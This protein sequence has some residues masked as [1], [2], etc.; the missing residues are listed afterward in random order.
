M[1][2]IGSLLMH[3]GADTRGLRRAEG[4]VKGFATR[5]S[6]HLGKVT[7]S[8]TGMYAAMAGT[9][10]IA[11]V[12]F[13]FAKAVKAGIEFEHT[14]KIVQGVSRA[15][16]SEF[17]KMTAVAKH[18][19]ETTE[20]T[21]K[22]AAEG[23]KF[24]SMAGF[25][26]SQTVKAMPGVLD[27]ATAG[28]VDL[29]R[30][31]DI[32]T[33]AL[34][35]FRLEVGDLSRVND[36][37][38]N[39]ITRSNTDMEQMAEAFKYAAPTAKAFGYEVEEV[40]ALIG[41]LGNAGIQGS[42]AGTQLAFAMQKAALVADD[43]YLANDNLLSVLQHL[44]EEGTG[45]TEFLKL[46][47]QRGGRAA[48]ILRELIPETK[49]FTNVIRENEGATKS[50]ADMM[51]S[52]TLVALNELESAI[53][54]IAIDAFAEY[55]EGLQQ[56]IRDTTSFVREIK[57]VIIDL[58][59][60]FTKLSAEISS[61]TTAI[62]QLIL[63]LKAYSG[64]KG[65]MKDMIEMAAGER[66][67]TGSPIARGK[68]PFVPGSSETGDFGSMF[69]M[70]GLG[71]ETGKKYQIP[72]EYTDQAK[73]Y[74]KE[75]EE[76]VTSGQAIETWGQ[77]TMTAPGMDISMYEA[78]LQQLGKLDEDRTMFLAEQ[79]AAR[80]Q[81]E[82]EA[83]LQGYT[84][85]EVNQQA[86]RDMT[87]EHYAVMSEMVKQSFQENHELLDSLNQA[88]GLTWDEIR[89]GQVD[90][91]S[92]MS[93]VVANVGANFSAVFQSVITGSQTASQALKNFGKA[94]ISQIVGALIKLGIQTVLL[95]ATQA[96]SITAA[97]ATVAAA[98]KV[99][100]N[101]ASQAAINVSIATYGSAAAVGLAAYLTAY[102]TAMAVNLGSNAAGGAAGGD[103]AGAAG[104]SGDFGGAITSFGRG[105]VITGPTFAMMGEEYDEAVVPLAPWRRAEARSILAQILPRIGSISGG[106][107]S[108]SVDVG[109]ID[110]INEGQGYD[111][112]GQ[113][114]ARDIVRA[115]EGELG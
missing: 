40:A 38:I 35:A 64:V 34:T 71:A 3:L 72:K 102:G 52:D 17:E 43:N 93:N 103:L 58:T 37:F 18:L 101:A 84:G 27:L 109:G 111:E 77:S 89:Q 57:P 29:A 44:N 11:G 12:G 20:W 78:H 97:G 7:R 8:F 82:A 31:A 90:V 59:A 114:A 26:A 107:T 75:A 51:R 73:K 104:F 46:F 80:L 87:Q 91:W 9:A 108:A 112:I 92:E 13:A 19:G 94:I 28:N 42:M 36:A 25:Q 16:T 45:A 79:E 60:L 98:M 113:I 1:G 15:T 56:A 106:G 62:G 33:N 14:M 5:T 2:Y 76:S 6:G 55:G 63:A 88:F 81:A 86:I 110:I 83:S 4:E 39:T 96:A 53:T 54:G 10:A 100:N 95:A 99:I 24:L 85:I 69:M 30:A 21:A 47:G 50:L 67:I 48:L 23:M 66:R 22:Q 68:I 61:P 65:V 41:T 32:S 115:L 74:Q 105:G 49:N 70:E